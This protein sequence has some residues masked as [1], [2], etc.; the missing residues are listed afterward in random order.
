MNAADAMRTVTVAFELHLKY[1]TGAHGREMCQQRR[2][3][4]GQQIVPVNYSFTHY[5]WTNMN[6]TQNIMRRCGL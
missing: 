4:G 2:E 6:Y 1:S 5:I 3:L